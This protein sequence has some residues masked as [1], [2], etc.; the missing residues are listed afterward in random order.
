M[1]PRPPRPI[2]AL[3]LIS[4]C[5]PGAEEP[6][7]SESTP[8]TKYGGPEVR[9]T[10]TYP[11]QPETV[12]TPQVPL[13]GPRIT[14]A[15]GPA[16]SVDATLRPA[17]QPVPEVLGPHV[18]PFYPTRQDLVLMGL[19]SEGTAL[20]L[21]LRSDRPK[22]AEVAYGEVQG[23]V[24]G[25]QLG[26]G[27]GS[28]TLDLSWHPTTFDLAYWFQAVDED[29]ERGPIRQL[30]FSLYT[31]EFYAAHGRDSSGIL[32]LNWSEIPMDHGQ[33]E[34]WWHD[35]ASFADIAFARETWGAEVERETTTR[36]KVRALALGI[37]GGIALRGG[38]P[39]D[40]LSR[41]PPFE[42]YRRA[43]AGLGELWCDNHARIFI[44]AA[45]AFGI[46]ARRVELLGHCESGETVTV[47]TADGHATTEYF[48]EEENRWLWID[49][50]GRVL[51]AERSNGTAL[52]V[53]Q[54]QRAFNDPYGDP[55]IL[56]VYDPV[57]NTIG[58]FALDPKEPRWDLKRFFNPTQRFQYY[59]RAPNM[60]MGD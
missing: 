28:V 52:D 32:V 39:S 14:V 54:F 42:Q 46:A 10:A 21:A 3:L 36:G 22:F 1:R 12:L 59:R 23:G 19:R 33:V 41:Q 37:M 11:N 49:L 58:N 47:C 34:D 43:A 56:E 29:G 38:V 7:A 15:R 9:P 60:P 25:P 27:T 4:A 6:T 35:R 13:F 57:T 53:Q 26:T 16:P 55:V 17:E 30:G 20:T 51:K 24:V 18:E 5:A 31:A 44:R 50:T 48:D 8:Q 2:A 40:D 45:T